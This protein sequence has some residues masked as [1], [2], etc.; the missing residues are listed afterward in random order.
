MTIYL[1]ENIRALRRDNNVTQEKL[2]EFLG[3]T[4]QSI[5]NWE[6]GESYPDIT[7]LPEIAG[8]FNVSIDNLLGMNKTLKEKKIHEY[9]EIYNN[10]RYKNTSLTFKTFQQAIKDF[11]K[12]YRITV[13]YMELLMC[14]KTADDL[15]EFEKCSH[16]LLNIYEDIQTHCTDDSVRMWSKRLICQHLH[17][18][19]YYKN[20]NEY[21]IQTEKILSEMPDMLNTKDYL[22][23]MLITDSEKH[24]KACSDA[25]ENMLVLINNTAT[26]YCFYDE[27]FSAEYK[28]EAAKKI[29]EINDIIFSDRNYG[30]LWQ[31][32]IYNYGHLGQWY[33]D[34]SDEEPALYS[35]R[36]SA[37]LAYQYDNLPLI[38]ERKA[39]FF[40]NRFFDK[41]QHGK[42]MCQRMKY[43]FTDKYTFSDEFRKRTEFKDIIKLLDTH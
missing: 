25:I 19:S 1:G 5:S 27:N 31:S 11:P 33:Y 37:E 30:R 43:L 4:F 41:V 14:E 23:T 28:I 17:T 35:L 22:S 20:N 26:H 42:T 18:K 10:L 2:A 15:S 32:M 29:I 34:I 21:Q 8:F 16:E 24:Y 38:S 13:R 7:L 9:L 40:E 36:K 12:D 3:V 6:R 39:Q